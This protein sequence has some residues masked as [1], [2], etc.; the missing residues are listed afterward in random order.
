MGRHCFALF[1]A[2]SHLQLQTV[3]GH[4]AWKIP[5]HPWISGVE[6][7]T[8]LYNLETDP[9]QEHPLQNQEIEAQLVDHMVKMM[10]W[11]DAPPEQFNRM[12]L[13]E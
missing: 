11:N 10:N 9:K 13:A 6:H 12:G 8:K 3:T 7:A 4:P 2:E 5:V 1:Q